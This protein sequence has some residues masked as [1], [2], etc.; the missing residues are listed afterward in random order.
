MAS[1]KLYHYTDKDS[2]ESIKASGKIKASRQENAADDAVFGDGAY[3]AAMA[4]HE[5]TK[6]EIA[7]NNYDS[8]PVFMEQKLNEGNI[9]NYVEVDIPQN[10]PQL[11][12]ITDPS[13]PDRDV[14]IYK[15]DIDLAHYDHKFGKHPGGK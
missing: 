13:R 5:H 1:K 7:K 6:E 11:E 8:G 10:D 12:Q 3:L 4:P 9:D 15:G 2:C 14:A